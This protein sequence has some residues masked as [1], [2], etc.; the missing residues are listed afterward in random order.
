M[1][2]LRG[3]GEGVS[4][5]LADQWV[6]FSDFT[7]TVPDHVADFAAER[8]PE[9]YR[10]DR[11]SVP[12]DARSV[13]VVRDAGLGDVLL[14]TPLLR[15][16]KARGVKRLG[17]ATQHAYAPLLGGNPDVDGVHVIDSPKGSDYRKGYA[18][19]IDLRQYVEHREQITRS[20]LNRVD[21]FGRAAEVEFTDDAQRRLTYV[22]TDAER[23]WAEK[24][25]E[26][27]GYGGTPV[28]ALV[29]RASQP[30]RSL[31]AEDVWA[32]AA[33]LLGRGWRVA[34]LDHEPQDPPGIY[35]A[36]RGLL[37]LTG[38]LTIRQA[39]A[40]L[41][42]CD[43]VCAPDTGMFHL[44]SAL[45]KDIVTYFGAFPLAERRSHDAVTDCASGAGCRL[46]PCRRYYC[47][48]RDA[49]GTPRCLPT[50]EALADTIDRTYRQKT[51]TPR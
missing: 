25:L 42:A 33:S 32:L 29:F 8:W 9:H 27:N 15:A 24:T 45:G 50:P 14:V 41:D 31:L 26:R 17:V 48:V 4:V 11:Q 35:S 13:L 16:L 23:A 18:Q 34:V 36:A 30:N 3:P 44:A 51:E 38:K 19:V 39:G 40:V 12:A 6:T 37:N 10:I 46:F 22:V 7:A 28:C 49:R 21:A 47:M 1:K 43:V 5:K 2:I 20:Y